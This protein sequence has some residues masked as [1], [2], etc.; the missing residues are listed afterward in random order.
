MDWFLLC[1]NAGL[2]I[3]KG[4]FHAVME[5]RG[6][7]R[8]DRRRMVVEMAYME[9]KRGEGELVEWQ[10]VARRRLTTGRVVRGYDGGDGGRRGRVQDSTVHAAVEW[11]GRERAPSP[12][13]RVRSSHSSLAQPPKAIASRS[14]I[15]IRLHL[16]PLRTSSS[17]I[18][19]G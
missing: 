8:R 18:H 13:R 10:R 19:H 16:I 1:K 2:D 3:A 4:C 11:A 5:Q 15:A 12:S 6:R 14:P 17:H 7:G 9:E